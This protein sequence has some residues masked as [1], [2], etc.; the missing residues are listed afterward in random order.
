MPQSLV[1]NIHHTV[2][3]TKGRHKWI[4]QEWEADLFRQI[5]GILQ[6]MG[7]KLLAAGGNSDHIHLLSSIERKMSIPEYVAK[8]K[9]AS[10][11]WIHRNIPGKKLFA[12]QN[13]YASFSVSESNIPA[14][15]RYIRQQRIHHQRYAFQ[16]ELKA[17]LERHKLK[18]DERWLWN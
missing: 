14:V 13:G 15:T 9:S 12:W 1:Q 17:L 5:G 6:R 10:S 11:L 7:C 3:S 18:Y 4:N 8:V 2:F 16:I